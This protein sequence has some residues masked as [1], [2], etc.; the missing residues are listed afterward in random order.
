VL[1]VGLVLGV[2]ILV[3]VLAKPAFAT[4]ALSF[5]VSFSVYIG[6]RL[7]TYPPVQGPAPQAGAR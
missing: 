7:F 6:V 4:A 1:R 3:G 2:L 5:L